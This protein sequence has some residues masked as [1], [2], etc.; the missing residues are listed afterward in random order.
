[1]DSQDIIIIILIS[2]II[3]MLFKMFNKKNTHSK[4]FKKC[5]SHTINHTN[6]PI[7]TNY[8]MYTTN[9][10]PNNNNLTFTNDPIHTHDSIHTNYP[11]VTNNQVLS[12]PIDTN[13]VQSV[14]YNN[15]VHNAD[16]T[17]L[18]LPNDYEHRTEYNPNPTY[19]LVYPT[20]DHNINCPDKHFTYYEDYF[21]NEPMYMNF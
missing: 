7:H 16:I 20:D 6:N 2:L 10:T 15:D 11:V 8:P 1:M 17:D 12:V 18:S 5:N 4:I 21:D 19:E 13:V 14:K 3:Y 9:S